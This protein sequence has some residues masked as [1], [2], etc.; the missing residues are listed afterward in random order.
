[1]P[2]K[3]ASNYVSRGLN[4]KLRLDLMEAYTSTPLILYYKANNLSDLS[5][6]HKTRL[7]SLS[8]AY[9]MTSSGL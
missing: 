8:F 5:S 4:P 9:R 7:S 6:T 3:L 2:P 1:M